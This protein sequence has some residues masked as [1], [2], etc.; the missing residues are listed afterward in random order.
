MK[1]VL[2][3]ISLVI[4]LAACSQQR[5]VENPEVE[6]VE[7]QANTWQPLGGA[8]DVVTKNNAVKPK[9]ILDRNGKPV[10]VWAEDNGLWYLQAKRWNGTAWEK[11]PLPVKELPYTDTGVND[12]D[13][14]FDKSNALV[15]SYIAGDD[16]VNV[17]RSNGSS[18]QSINTPF[19]SGFFNLET[20]KA[21]NI[22]TLAQSEVGMIKKNII[23]RW[24]G[25]AWQNVANLEFDTSERNYA[26][27]RFFVTTDGKP[28]L[29]AYSYRPISGYGYG[30]YSWTGTAWTMTGVIGGTDPDVLDITLDGLNR[31]LVYTLYNQFRFE[32]FALDGSSRE[33]LGGS[34]YT[35]NN[36][37]ALLSA[38]GT[39][40]PLRIN[41][42]SKEIATTRFTVE[43]WTGSAWTVMGAALNR[44]ANKETRFIQAVNDNAGNTYIAWIEASCATPGTCGGANVYVS[45]YAETPL[46]QS[47][48]WA[49]LGDPTLGL[50]G[51]PESYTYSDFKVYKDKIYVIIGNYLR[52]WTG[53]TWTTLTTVESDSRLTVNASGA[54]FS[55]YIKN[56][57][58]YVKR[59]SGT[60]W[61]QLGATFA[62]EPTEILETYAMYT[63]SQGNPLIA[64]S[65]DDAV[66]NRVVLRVNQWTGS[67]WQLVGQPFI[68]SRFSGEAIRI[69]DFTV[70][71]S[72]R[73]YIFKFKS[74]GGGEYHGYSVIRWNGTAWQDLG[75]ACYSDTI[76]GRGV[77]AHFELIS[78][79]PNVICQYTNSKA[80]SGNFTDILK[81]NGSSFTEAIKTIN[82]KRGEFGFIHGAQGGGIFHLVNSR[83]DGKILVSRLVNGKLEA[84][85]TSLSG[86]QGYIATS[87][88]TGP[89]IGYYL[90]DK[91]YI[92][93]WQ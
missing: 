55:S 44:E 13:V 70:D 48:S 66:K 18:F 77:F 29:L 46:P 53:G 40:N 33:S 73:P 24:N 49:Q 14:A 15:L 68:D 58:V 6:N 25:S 90:N 59:W 57:Q 19:A 60:A 75:N 5:A 34:S 8:L 78:N 63:N 71:G 28:V 65:T 92:S 79:T 80:D 51:S 23:Q 72:N 32:R 81:W 50:P 62:K 85:G 43:R 30:V 54:L 2:T 7:A 3:L 21:G 83:P 67:A 10:V 27:T 56:G 87:S 84:F 89:V 86:Y 37:F 38:D 26:V 61:Q 82:Y 52:S 45:K 4:L 74:Q 42:A 9:L 69:Q 36:F 47:K 11:L 1:K 16:K 20:D 93:R 22:Y 17:T 39:N 91:V 12:F 35:T 76:E 88:T 41:P 31:V 64:Y